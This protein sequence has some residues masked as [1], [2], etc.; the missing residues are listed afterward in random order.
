MGFVGRF[1]TTGKVFIPEALQKELETEYLHDIVKK[2][3]ENNIPVSLVLNLD[4]TFSKYVPIS[5][6][7]LAQKGAKTVSIKGSND[8]RMITATLHSM[9]NFCPCC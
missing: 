3:E 2:I 5:N 1:G 6:K 8:K 7:T 4:R 9:I